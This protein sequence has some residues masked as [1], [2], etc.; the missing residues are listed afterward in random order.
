MARFHAEVKES[1]DVKRPDL[2]ELHQNMTES[3]SEIHH[4]I[5][6]CMTTTLSEVKRAN[7]SV[8]TAMRLR[9]TFTDI[10]MQLDLDDL[11]IDNA[12]FKSFDMIVRRMLDPVWHKV[13]PRTKQLVGDLSVLRRMLR[14]AQTSSVTTVADAHAR[15]VAIC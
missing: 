2:V 15:M 1:L 3:M 13:G 10:E 7:T 14:S 4:A 6:Q 9:Y 8:R 11:S 12:Y 5:V